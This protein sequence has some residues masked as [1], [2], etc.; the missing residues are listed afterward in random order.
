[1]KYITKSLIG[2]ALVG[3]GPEVAHI[4]LV[5]GSKDGAVETAFMNSFATPRAGHTP[6]LAILEPNLPIKPATL[7]INKV[8]IKNSS[9]VTLMFGPAQAAIAKAVID[10]VEEKIID[11]DEVENILI[12]VSIFI[13]WDARDKDKI[14]NNNYGATKLALS[15]AMKKEPSVDDVLARKDRARHPFA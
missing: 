8:T 6:L 9:Q 2:E 5:V 14:Y 10:S 3:N 15:R 1:M 12:I 11:K 13:A 7:I 4:D